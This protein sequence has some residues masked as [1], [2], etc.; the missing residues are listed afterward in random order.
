M[1]MYFLLP[2]KKNLAE[3][4]SVPGIFAIFAVYSIEKS[5]FFYHKDYKV[6]YI[7]EGKQFKK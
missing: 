7:L 6:L 4:S 2:W 5:D 3:F 1:E